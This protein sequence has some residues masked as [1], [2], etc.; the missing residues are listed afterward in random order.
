MR[1]TLKL[2]INEPRR[3]WQ[4][5]HTGTVVNTV[6]YL[7]YCWNFP[8]DELCSTTVR[9]FESALT[10]SEECGCQL[11]HADSALQSA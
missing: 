9:Q 2:C 8:V 7:L 10:A 5:H 11:L 6:Y 4:W 3:G 1:Q